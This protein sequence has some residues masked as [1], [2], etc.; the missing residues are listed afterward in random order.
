MDEKNRNS[1]K[2]DIEA[3][4]LQS[5]ATAKDKQEQEA[6]ESYKKLSESELDQ[7]NPV[8]TAVPVSD[9][10]GTAMVRENG[11]CKEGEDESM[12][13]GG[14]GGDAGNE[15]DKLAEKEIEVKFISEQNGDARIDMELENQ[16]TF[17]GMT[18]DELMKFANDPFWI[19]LRWFLFIVFWGL[20]IAMLAGAIYIIM[21]AP[22]C[23]APIP[24]S[25]WQEGPLV[26]IDEQNYKAQSES[27]KK[28]GAKGVIYALPSDETYLV[29]T[30]SVE[31]KIKELVGTF[32]A[33]DIKVILDLTPN[34][35]TKDDQLF[36]D[37]LETPD[38]PSRSAFIWK[39]SGSTPTNW[40]AVVGDGSAWKEVTAQQFVLSQFGADRYDLQLSNALAKEKLK[41][42]LR[43]LAK[44][45]VRGFRLANAK[46]FIVDPEGK[47]DVNAEVED[48]T[49]SHTDYGF[50]THSH[51]TYQ[52]GLGAL[53]HELS[54]DLRNATGG[55]GFLSV[56]EDIARPEVFTV[57]GKFGVDLPEFGNVES[58]LRE[59]IGS[60]SAKLIRDDIRKTYSEIETYRS[61]E[62][63]KPW[64]QWP[65]GKDSLSNVAAS[66]YNMF[67]FLLPGVPVVPLDVL[68][69]G[70]H[71]HTVIDLLEKYRASPSYQHGSFA[72]YTDANETSIGYTRL[73]SGNPG[74]F[75]A[76]NLA[77]QHVEADFS[78]VEGI[79]EE[80]T[81]VLTSE[82]FRV[83]DV[84]AKS[85]VSSK[86]V[87]LSARSALIATY[88]PK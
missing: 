84:A 82:N 39:Q 12:L 78:G 83:P 49:L 45:G 27:V 58:V 51:T 22:K 1:A 60:D 8:A 18:K 29:N 57:G 15:K 28:Y 46:H 25:W 87:P 79:A 54:M 66:E 71:S 44:L 6:K 86:A 85:K 50:W 53:L 88:V 67:M 81:I 36:K 55:D 70:N 48:K 17:S 37:A 72:I 74:Y 62:G 43:H 61:V 21:D 10:N 59:S 30:A 7:P 35:V 52:E 63:G 20:W 19:R 5:A 77:D 42:T 47:N 4:R 14:G 31:N 75:V 33:K 11:N 13:N 80:L 38:S 23:A 32:T 40:L 34:F 26:T 68:N 3:A 56:N 16:Q 24:L 76:L 69:Y 73:K 41:L 2:L 64:V 65:Y 9:V